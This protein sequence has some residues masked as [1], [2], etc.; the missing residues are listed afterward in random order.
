MGIIGRIQQHLSYDE[1]KADLQG[2]LREAVNRIGTLEVQSGRLKQER[3]RAR[4]ERDRA[5][6]HL[7]KIRTT[8][9]IMT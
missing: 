5:Q 2:R 9:A 7:E 4:E 8:I 3:D 1:E 6:A